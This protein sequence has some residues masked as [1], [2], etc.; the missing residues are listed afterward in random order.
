MSC[1]CDTGFSGPHCETAACGLKCAHGGVP[2]AACTVC[3]GCHGGWG[4]K[5]CDTWNP[6]FPSSSVQQQL[7]NLRNTSQDALLKSLAYNPICKQGQ[8]CVG[9]GVDLGAGAK[10]KFPLLTLDFSGTTPTWH[11]FKY[12]VGTDVIPSQFP[13][14]TLDTQVFNNLEEFR[15]FVD[16][17]W[18]DQQG[19]IGYYAQSAAASPS[20]Q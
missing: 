12:P 18:H 14:F 8:E 7:A 13:D 4:G 20:M 16:A 11:G 19:P 3:Q 2:D 6:A 10:A 5:L 17:R 15:T 9:W 1:A